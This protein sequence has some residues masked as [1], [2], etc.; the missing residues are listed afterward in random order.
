MKRNIKLFSYIVGS[1]LGMLFISSCNK[2]DDNNDNNPQMLSEWTGD[3]T[4][5]ETDGEFVMKLY[6]DSSIK[7][8]FTAYDGT[9]GI[10]SMGVYSLKDTVFSF[11]ASGNAS[12]QDEYDNETS[13]VNITGE[14]IMKVNDAVGTYQCEF[15]NDF[16]T[17]QSGDW[18]AQK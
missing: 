18:E 6:A 15:D 4:G 7:V 5:E 9:F 17:D 8:D 14:G 2:D 13:E 16:F 12:Y 10:L 11:S 3:F 1:I